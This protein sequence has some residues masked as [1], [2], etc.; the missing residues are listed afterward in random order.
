MSSGH[1]LQGSHLFYV[2]VQRSNIIA[3]FIIQDGEEPLR[4]DYYVDTFPNI[5]LSTS[6]DIHDILFSTPGSRLELWHHGLW[7]IISLET[8]INVQLIPRILLRLRP[9]LLIQLTDCPGLED[10]IAMQSSVRSEKSVGKRR[11]V[12]PLTSLITKVPRHDELSTAPSSSTISRGPVTSERPVP[13]VDS[14]SV[15]TV[16]VLSLSQS[17][18]KQ[19]PDHFSNSVSAQRSIIEDISRDC[20]KKTWPLTISAYEFNDGLQQLARLMEDG[21]SQ[22]NAF[23]KAFPGIVKANSNKYPRTT[24]WKYKTYWINAP[25]SLKEQFLDYGAS[26]E[27]LMSAFVLQLHRVAK[28]RPTGTPSSDTCVASDSTSSSRISST[29]HHPFDTILQSLGPVQQSPSPPPVSAIVH[30]QETDNMSIS[31]SESLDGLDDGRPLCPFCD[32]PMESAQSQSLALM[33]ED[34]KKLSWPMRSDANPNHR[35]AESFTVYANFCEL[36]RFESIHMP[37][38]IANHW[39]F[40]IDFS[41]LHARVLRLRPQLTQVMDD[42]VAKKAD[43]SK[44]FVDAKGTA[45]KNVVRAEYSQFSSGG[46]G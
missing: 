11:A 2:W 29:I 13:T 31:D 41:A 25:Q 12:E 45:T 33:F 22:R 8:P 7:T 39:P 4:I 38:A 44:F 32:Q 40:K 23:I 5:Q 18:S 28:K 42:I 16:P 19:L 6:N 34:L 26:S 3:Y 10:E 27:G 15:L 46:V 35:N 21:D 36:H 43:P 17:L 30:G 14:T 9:S 37:V 1:F 20:T 24:L